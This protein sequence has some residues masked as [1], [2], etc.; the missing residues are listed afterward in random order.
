M[1]EPGDPTAWL[2]YNGRRHRICSNT[3]CHDLFVASFAFVDFYG[4]AD[5]SRG[6]DIVEGAALIRAGDSADVY[7]IV[8]ALDGRVTGYSIP[9]LESFSDFGFDMQKVQSVPGLLLEML[10]DG[11]PISSAKD[12][13]STVSD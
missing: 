12:R 9:T 6:E 8:P 13:G 11:G 3:T 10:A 2:I 4:V 1:R 5:I 7:L